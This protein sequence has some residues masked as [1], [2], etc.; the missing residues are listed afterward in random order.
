MMWVNIY[1]L[2]FI[3]TQ[4]KYD[5]D[6]TN[7]CKCFMWEDEF[8]LWEK[9]ICN[10]EIGVK[11]ENKTNHINSWLKLIF[12]VFSV[13]LEDVCS[14]LNKNWLLHLKWFYFYEYRF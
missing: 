5:P 14:F 13:F 8:F 10:A 6:K 3:F 1:L 4:N 12:F 7:K 2:F 11:I 9:F